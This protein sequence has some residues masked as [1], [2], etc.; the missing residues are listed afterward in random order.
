[1]Q[2]WESHLALLGLHITVSKI[3]ETNTFIYFQECIDKQLRARVPAWVPGALWKT[4]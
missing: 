2:P 1:M 3:D 4:R